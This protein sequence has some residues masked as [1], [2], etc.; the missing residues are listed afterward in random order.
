[1]SIS[2]MLIFLNSSEWVRVLSGIANIAHA[3]QVDG[4]SNSSV[5]HTCQHRHSAVHDGQKAA[6]H[7]F[8]HLVELNGGPS[9]V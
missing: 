5:V 3:Y 8:D 7:E 1:M 2:L 6:L 9:L 4:A